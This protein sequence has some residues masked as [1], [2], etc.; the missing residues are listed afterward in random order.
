VQRV[1][2]VGTSGSGKTTLAGAIA[3]RLGV[4]H[5]ELDALHWLPGWAERPAGEFRADVE[6][7][8]ARDAWALD[9]NYGSVRDIVWSRATHVIWLDFAFSLVFRRVLW[10]TLRR[11]VTREEVCNGN[12][13]SLRLAF[14]DRES[15]L[16]WMIQ[17]HRR[18]RRTYAEL[19]SGEDHPH[20]TF[21][22]L[23]SPREAEALLAEIA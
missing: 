19:C 9:G 1:V 21:I 15:I 4:P 13:E 14:F 5:I 7:S 16:L 2:V 10:R 22:E 6:Q 17:T 20:V 11:I 18:R 23:R 3:Q 8:V 12:R